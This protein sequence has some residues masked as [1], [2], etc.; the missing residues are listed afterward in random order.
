M[1]R[2]ELVAMILNALHECGP[3]SRAEIELHLKHNKQATA[4]VLSRLHKPTAHAGKRIYI[5]EW[6][7]DAERGRRY[8]RPV[9]AVGDLEDRPKPKPSHAA[10][11]K[12]HL[13]A[14]RKRVNS[15]FA[16]GQAFSTPRKTTKTNSHER[17]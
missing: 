16:L 11:L 6:I 10:N 5:R 13:E 12:R 9:Y 2:G 15:V 14:K 1:K 17:T 4:S 7:Y 3:M 8:P